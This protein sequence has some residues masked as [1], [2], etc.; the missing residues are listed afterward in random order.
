MLRSHDLQLYEPLHDLGYNLNFNYLD[1]NYQNT[2]FSL[3]KH[4]ISKSDLKNYRILKFDLVIQR[5]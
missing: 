2:K 4:R 3:S 1:Y 5:I